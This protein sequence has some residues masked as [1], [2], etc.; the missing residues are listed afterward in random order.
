MAQIRKR[1]Q[2]QYQARVRLKG[3]PEVSKTFPTKQ[4]AI[5]WAAEREGQLLQG[6]AGALREAERLTLGNALDRYAEE[7]SVHK[8]GYLQE[9]KRVKRWKREPMA[10]LPLGHIRGADMA[11]YRDGRMNGGVSGNTVR[12]DLA[13][14]SHLYEVAR[15]D[16]GLE[17]LDNPVKACRKPKVSRGRDR[18]LM[19]GEEKALLN[20]CG[21]VGNTR[22]KEIIILAIETAMRR[23]ELIRGLRWEDVDLERR[24]AYLRDTKNGEARAVPLSLRATATLQA[25]QKDSLGFVIDVDRDVVTRDFAAT[26]KTCEI[27]DLRLHDLRHEAT[28]RLFEKGFNMMEVSTITGHKSLSMLKRY[29][30]LR[31]ADLLSRLG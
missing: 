20:Y 30:H 18:R 14:I 28:S 6:L 15:K 8:K 27:D 3:Y 1:G 4:E 21:E 24:I 26:C 16:W 22:L 9:L 2:T 7:V 11:R 31:P 23:S 12:L 17:T 5:L 10:S 29:T 13:L 25:M 19:P